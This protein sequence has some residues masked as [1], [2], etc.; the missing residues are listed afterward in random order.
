[1]V[2]SVDKMQRAVDGT[3]LEK[4]YRAYD[5]A[6]VK[7]KEL[8]KQV[9]E[10]PTRLNVSYAVGY[11]QALTD[12]GQSTLVEQQHLLALIVMVATEPDFYASLVAT[13]D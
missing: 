7:V 4:L 11:M 1:M 5:T 9:A 8:V 13:R 12:F 3:S 2:N 10:Q 6:S